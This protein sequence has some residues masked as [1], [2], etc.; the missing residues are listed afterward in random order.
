MLSPSRPVPRLHA[1]VRVNHFS[2]E[3]E[4]GR[5]IGIQDEGRR[6]EIALQAG[7]RLQFTLSQATARYVC[8]AANHGCR[9][10]LLEDSQ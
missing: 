9:L 4:L 2:G 5:I 3:S 6:L 8:G 10:T 7:A 1:P